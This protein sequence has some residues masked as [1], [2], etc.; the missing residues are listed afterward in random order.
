[1]FVDT[2]IKTDDVRTYYEIPDATVERIRQYAGD[3]DRTLM[4]DQAC[5]AVCDEL[6]RCLECY[7]A[8]RDSYK[9]LG[10]LNA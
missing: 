8:L 9:A 3:G 10:D 2:A 1:M 7:G 5:E 6:V 4:F